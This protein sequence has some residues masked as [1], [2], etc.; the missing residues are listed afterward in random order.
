MKC[1]S[2]VKSGVDKIQSMDICFCKEGYQ[3]LGLPFHLKQFLKKD[4]ICGRMAFQEMKT[5]RNIGHQEMKTVLSKRQETNEVS[6]MIASAYCIERVS[7]Q[8]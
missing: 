2:V 8:T 5:S 6:P 4:N 1:K 3:E 7:R